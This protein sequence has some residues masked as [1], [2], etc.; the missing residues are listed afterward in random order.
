M[1]PVD[2]LMRQLVDARDA[3]R[4]RD[5]EID[6]MANRIVLLER[7]LWHIANDDCDLCDQRICPT[8][9]DAIQGLKP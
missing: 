6:R 4:Q 9:S 2:A 7:A 3:L 8:A 5:T 1:N